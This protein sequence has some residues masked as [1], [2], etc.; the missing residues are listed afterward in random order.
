MSRRRL[1]GR[2]RLAMVALQIQAMAIRSINLLLPKR[3]LR[4]KG[5]TLRY[6]LVAVLLISLPC[7]GQTSTTGQATTNKP[8]SVANTGSGNKI[9]VNCGL[10]PKIPAADDIF[11][12]ISELGARATIVVS[13]NEEGDSLRSTLPQYTGFLVYPSERAVTCLSASEPPPVLYPHIVAGALLQPLLRD[14]AQMYGV[15]INRQAEVEARTRLAVLH[16]LGIQVMFVPELTFDGD[17]GSLRS[18]EQHEIPKLSSELPNVGDRVFMVGVESGLHPRL[19]MLEG[20]VVSI[21]NGSAQ[22]V[23]IYITLPFKESYCGAPL[24]NDKKEIV[25]MVEKRS[26]TSGE[27]EAIPSQYIRTALKDITAQLPY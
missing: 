15:I 4:N 20:R 17:K 19:S 13:A 8:C 27:V 12:A 23:S 1:A 25:G 22:G 7:R 9:H 5:V 26:S 14:E 6:S 16:V 18:V 24:F 2:Q 3:S 11:H 10:I 21:G